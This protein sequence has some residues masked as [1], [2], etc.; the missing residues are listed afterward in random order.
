MIKKEKIMDK[1]K[2]AISIGSLLAVLSATAFYILS[3][4]PTAAPPDTAAVFGTKD[5]E[6]A[7]QCTVY[8]AQTNQPL[9]GAAVAIGQTG[10]FSLTDAS[11][12]TERI[13]V[14]L[15]RDDAFDGFAPKSWLEATVAVYAEGYLPC[16]VFGVQ[17]PQGGL[18]DDLAIYLVPQSQSD[19]TAAVILTE[20][21]DRTWTE[22]LLAALRARAAEKAG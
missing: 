21:P 5:A 18:R 10:E 15:D 20:S 16:C 13:P 1:K 14:A 19:S 4:L 3:S 9:P 2:I 11:G 12:K 7:L 17:I 8:D 22:S 6:S